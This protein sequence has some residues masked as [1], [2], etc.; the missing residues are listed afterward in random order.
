MNKLVPI[1]LGAAA[2]V[3]ALVVGTR[4]LGPTAQSAVGVAPSAT[5]STTPSATPVETAQPSAAAPSA[6]TPPPLSQSFTSQIH[7][8]SLSYPEGWTAR[9]ATE[10]WTDRPGEAPYFHPGYDVLQDP[11]QEGSLHLRIT[12]RPIGGSTPEDWVAKMMADSG[13][14]TTEQITVDGAP[15]LIGAEGC[16]ETA[17]VTSAGRGYEIVLYTPNSGEHRPDPTYDRAWFEKVLATVRLHP[18]DAVDAAPSASP[19]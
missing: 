11:A 10:P 9:P 5:P 4:F 2:V 1:G 8:I 12:S 16:Q 14:T 19:S 7:G 17:G 6:N 18:E 3:L 13:C 15:G